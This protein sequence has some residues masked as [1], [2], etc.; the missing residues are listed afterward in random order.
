[1][2]RILHPNAPNGT[3]VFFEEARSVDVT[4]VWDTIVASMTGIFFF[5]LDQK[6]LNDFIDN[7]L[8]IKLTINT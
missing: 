8:R 7:F 2:Q 4:Q 5:F 6:T 3:N 1:M